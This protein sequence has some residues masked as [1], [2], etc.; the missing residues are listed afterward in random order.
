[1][2]AAR[3]GAFYFLIVFAAG[4]MLGAIRVF[5]V[6]PRLGETGAVVLELPVMLAV[7]WFTCGWLIAYMAA[8]HS[9]EAG[10]IMGLV[11][12]ALLLAA[13]FALARVGFGRSAAEYL[14]AFATPPGLIGL[15]GQIAFALFPA[16]RL[17]G[18]ATPAG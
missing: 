15:A 2:S 8:P 10:A 4:F 7:S 9:K 18:L 14:S 11:A 17:R 6:A 5:V 16:I 13:E 1:M 3:A 12:F